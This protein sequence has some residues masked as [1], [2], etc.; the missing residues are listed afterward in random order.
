VGGEKPRDDDVS[1][2]LAI[3]RRFLL[4]RGKDRKFKV[5]LICAKGSIIADG[6]SRIRDV[7]VSNTG[8]YNRIGS[9]RIIM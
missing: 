2:I 3:M 9:D 4:P 5:R 8:R 1:A 6:V 7:Q